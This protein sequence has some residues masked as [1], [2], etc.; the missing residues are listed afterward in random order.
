MHDFLTTTTPPPPFSSR[1]TSF[2]EAIQH[3][4]RTDALIDSSFARFSTAFRLDKKSWRRSHA[5]KEDCRLERAFG[6]QGRGP[7]GV[8][9]GSNPGRPKIVSSRP[10]PQP[11][12]SP[13]CL[14]P[15]LYSLTSRFSVFCHLLVAFTLRTS[16]IL[17]F[18]SFS[19]P[20]IWQKE[21]F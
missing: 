13:A 11:V 9:L 12:G 14:L 21:G 17:G 6:E 1:S 20:E 3:S 16:R 7:K 4:R 10:H 19:P 18:L 5:H 15:R 2:D 8:D